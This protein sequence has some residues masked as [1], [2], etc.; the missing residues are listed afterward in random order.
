VP[1][2]AQEPELAKALVAALTAAEA[3]QTRRNCGFE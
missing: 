2:G 3:A 1:L